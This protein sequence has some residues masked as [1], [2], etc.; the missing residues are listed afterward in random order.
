MSSRASIVGDAVRDVAPLLLGVA[1]FGIIAGVA[2]VDVGLSPIQAYSLS[3]V[4]F[5]GAAQLATLG[6][7]ARD[8]AVAVVILTPLVINARH[9]MYSAALAPWFRPLPAAGKAGLA[10]VM[11]DQAFAM[12]II[13]YGRREEPIGDRVVYYLGVALSLWL[14]WQVTTIIGIAVGGGIPPEWSLDFAVPLVFLALVF[15]AITD[16]PTAVAAVVGAAVAVAA[17]DLPFNLGLPVGAV[18]GIAAGY[19]TE[20]AA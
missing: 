12:S 18:S 15:P 9:I 17:A 10:Y 19:V 14:T 11:T 8:A 5:A 7:L 3:P 16:R 20:E 2:A 6:L 13:R 4:I 1:P